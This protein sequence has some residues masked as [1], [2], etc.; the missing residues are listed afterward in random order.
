VDSRAVVE[1]AQPAPQARLVV[2]VAGGVLMRIAGLV[3][4]VA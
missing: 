2:V 3:R 4:S 1:I